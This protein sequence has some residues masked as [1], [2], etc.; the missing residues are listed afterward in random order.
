[1]LN[2]LS[3]YHL[4]RICLF[5]A[6]N[7]PMVLLLSSQRNKC[8][9]GG[10]K[11]QLPL[12]LKDTGCLWGVADE[13]WATRPGFALL[14]GD[15]FQC[16]DSW[17]RIPFFEVWRLLKIF[18]AYWALIM[19]LAMSWVTGTHYFLNSNNSLQVDA[20]IVRISWNCVLSSTIRIG[21][22]W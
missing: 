17:N 19:F 15:F 9:C 14:S 21:K 18:H 13:N 7:C 3:F 12:G 20:I 2:K 16:G 10:N 6:Q 8:C 5:T 4:F 22:V 1:M 11:R